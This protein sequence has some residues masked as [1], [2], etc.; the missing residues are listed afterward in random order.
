MWNVY[1]VHTKVTNRIKKHWPIPV[2]T[3]ALKFKR[4]YISWQNAFQ[5]WNLSIL[6]PR[7]AWVI[8]TTNRMAKTMTKLEWNFI[9]FFFFAVVVKCFVSIEKWSGTE[10]PGIFL[11]R[12]ILQGISIWIYFKY[13]N[14]KIYA[15]D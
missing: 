4:R 10:G 5:I 15:G 14:F 3:Y 11:L 9:L 2:D 1:T 8:S 12:Y 6:P 7:H 13:Q